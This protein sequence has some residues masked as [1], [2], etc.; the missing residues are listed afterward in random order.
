MTTWALIA[1]GPS[2][3]AEQAAQVLEAGIPLGAIGNA[4]ALAPHAQFVAATDGGW[5]RKHPEAKSLPCRKFTMHTVPDLETVKV[6]G[7]Y[8]ICNSGVLG[9]ECARL[10]GASRILLLGF[11]MHGSHF[12][13]QYT[14]GLRNTSPGQRKQH[15]IQYA[16][17]ARVHRSIEVINCTPGSALTCF[18]TARL[19]ETGISE[20]AADGA[21]TGGSVR[22]R[23]AA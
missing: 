23:A 9:L 1:P 17:W 2:A 13:G 7:L 19:D 21:G 20:L 15:L 5:W 14:N 6:S 22:A 16:E 4:F 18:P 11:D 10:L 3:S 8:Q 12:F